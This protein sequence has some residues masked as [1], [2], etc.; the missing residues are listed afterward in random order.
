MK[1]L[2]YALLLSA[3]L[4]EC[5]IWFVSNDLGSCT[6]T[7]I[8]QY[9]TA[10]DQGTLSNVVDY[11]SIRAM[12]PNSGTGWGICQGGYVASD[13]S[14]VDMPLIIGTQC[15]YGSGLGVCDSPA[16]HG[17]YRLC[18]CAMRSPPPPPP[19][20][21]PPPRALPHPSRTVRGA[22]M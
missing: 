13:Q 5:V 15:L 22:G 19:S 10:C 6:Q 9:G 16:T 20:P 1:R 21:R 8:N 4:S 18:P 12:N 7:C 2:L 14:G 3:R 11:N 17:Q